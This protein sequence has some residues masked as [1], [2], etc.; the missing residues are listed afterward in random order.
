MSQMWSI[1]IHR[2]ISCAIPTSGCMSRHAP[3]NVDVNSAGRG[4]NSRVAEI[5]HGSLRKRCGGN[6]LG[7]VP[8]V[9]RLAEHQHRPLLPDDVEGALDRAVA[10]RQFLKAGRLSVLDTDRSPGH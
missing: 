5:I 2:G 7:W 1:S 8:A 6:L 9:K 4:A 3:T 10:P